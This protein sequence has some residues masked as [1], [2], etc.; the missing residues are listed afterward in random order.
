MKRWILC[1]SV[2]LVLSL[3]VGLVTSCGGTSSTTTQQPTSSQPTTTAPASK[4]I[5]KLSVGIPEG[6]PMV[7]ALIAWSKDFNALAGNRAEMQVYPGGVLGGSNDNFLSARNRTI[8]MAHLSIPTL[9]GYDPAF[10]V[11]NLPYCLDTYEADTEFCKLVRD[12]HDQIMQ[13]KFNQK[14]L[15][16]WCMGFGDVYTIKKQIKT[17]DDMKGQI[18]ACDK[19]IDAKSAE[20][21]GAS[22]VVMD[23]TEEYPALQKGVVTGGMA[24]AGGALGFMKYYEVVKYLTLS[25]KAPGQL[26]VSI[27]LDAYNSLPADLQK[28]MVDEGNKYQ[29]SMYETMKKFWLDSYNT[30]TQNGMTV[31]NLTQDERAKWVAACQPISDDYWKQVGPDA[32]TKLQGFLK[33]ANAK[34]P[35]K[36][37]SYATGQ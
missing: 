9:S 19:P 24:T 25:S 20:L 2:L 27:N 16:S 7:Q 5:L 36:G 22:A 10:G 18:F 35:Y 30:I 17:M 13:S 32:T 33:Q 1:I 34:Y 21:L 6:D 29:D 31:Y 14:Y 11:A 26:G 3:I 8:E 4:I 28:A 15:A 23:Y 37:Q 12:Y